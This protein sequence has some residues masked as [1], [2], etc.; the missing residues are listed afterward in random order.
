MKC[1]RKY[2]RNWTNCEESILRKTVK[3]KFLRQRTLRLVHASEFKTVLN[4]RP[5]LRITQNLNLKFLAEQPQIRAACT[6]S[7][8]PVLLTRDSCIMQNLV[9]P[10]VECCSYVHS[11][12]KY[13]MLLSKM[14]VSV[15]V[16]FCQNVFLRA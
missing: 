14:S 3:R 15:S 2:I 6:C 4:H 16:R 5:N 1:Q 10:V 8:L 9:V 7:N 11:R 13:L 12:S